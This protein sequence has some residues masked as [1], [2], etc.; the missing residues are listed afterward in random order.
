MCA[1]PLLEYEFAK[2]EEDEEESESSAEKDDDGL[3][4]PKNG[5]IV[6]ED[7]EAQ[8]DELENVMELETQETNVMHESYQ[9]PPPPASVIIRRD[10]DGK[11]CGEDIGRIK[12]NN[13]N[14]FEKCV[15]F[16]PGN[17]EKSSSEQPM[18]SYEK[19][20]RHKQRKERM[21][22][23]SLQKKPKAISAAKERRGV[24][25]LGIILGC[26]TICWTPFFIMYVIV[27][28]CANCSMNPHIEMFITWLGYSN[29][30]MNP[31]IYTVF[32]R[33]YQ[34]ALKRL[35]T[36]TPDKLPLRPNL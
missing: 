3:R 25:V 1:P 17:H 10:F 24:K 32:N 31:I 18:I 19:V 6:E 7:D 12:K 28:F 21:Y 16:Q 27:Q 14:N 9:N 36:N 35:F 23:K 33:D 13:K 5:I 30:A 34:I 15:A 22:R 20:K 26:F 4:L 29:S 11:P 2:E 8:C